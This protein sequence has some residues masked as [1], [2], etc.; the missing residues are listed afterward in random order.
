VGFRLVGFIT[1]T[2]VS[3]GQ[4]PNLKFV[5]RT[6]VDDWTMH[7]QQNMESSLR[8]ATEASN[9]SQYIMEK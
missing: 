9:N 2:A 6:L 1:A 5:G 3:G 4:L 8:Y 7:L